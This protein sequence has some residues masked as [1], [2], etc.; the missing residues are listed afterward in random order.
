MTCVRNGEEKDL[1]DI[2]ALIKE[3]AKY[4]LIYSISNLIPI[5]S[6]EGTKI[7]FIQLIIFRMCK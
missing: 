6:L 7:F 2:L 1:P 4:A 3:L 5:S